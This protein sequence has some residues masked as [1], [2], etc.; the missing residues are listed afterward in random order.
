[1]TL[2]FANERVNG[3]PNY[4]RAAP[5]FHDVE[6]KVHVVIAAAACD[7]T[8]R[9]LATAGSDAASMEEFVRSCGV[10]SVTRLTDRACTADRVLQAVEQACKLCRPD[11]YFVFY[12]SGYG[13]KSGYVS[14][15]GHS[16]GSASAF[17]CLDER[18]QVTTQSLLRWDDFSE[19]VLR[20]CHASVRILLLLD[21]V[22]LCSIADVSGPRWASRQAVAISGFN[23]KRSP[24]G[25]GAPGGLFTQA[26]L[27]A[28]GR[29]SM[30]GHE[31]YSAAVLYNATLKELTESF[32]AYQDI[33]IQCAPGWSAD[34]VAWPFVPAA[35]YEAPIYVAVQEDG[36][37][38]HTVHPTVLMC[39][40][41]ES[42]LAPVSV[43]EYVAY[44]VGADASEKG[45]RSCTARATRACYGPAENCTIQ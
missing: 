42:V 19:A 7:E 15:T 14:A 2:A 26:L 24:V 31:D 25:A 29:L 40:Q 37:G 34:Q 13:V 10:T 36:A 12:F 21:C 27:L 28:A 16:S 41:R 35:G 45:L 6:Q 1:M 18:G 20:S 8:N 43:E 5:A 44:V 32:M 38:R 23:E 39:V 22:H 3:Q 9:P 4:L 33:S 30:V 17:A 11:D